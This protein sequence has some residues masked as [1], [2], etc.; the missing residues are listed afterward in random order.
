MTNLTRIKISYY[1]S[2]A[3][4]T[5]AFRSTL[6]LT[7]CKDE[8]RKGEIYLD[9]MDLPRYE[10]LKLKY[11]QKLMNRRL[12]NKPYD[13]GVLVSDVQTYVATLDSTVPSLLKGPPTTYP[14]SRSSGSTVAH[15]SVSHQTPMT[16]TGLTHMDLDSLQTI[17][18]PLEPAAPPS[19]GSTLSSAEIIST[20]QHAMGSSSR[21]SRDSGRNS[22]RG[23]KKN[24]NCRYCDKPGHFW[25]ECFTYEN[26]RKSNRLRAGWEEREHRSR[27]RGPRDGKAGRHK[28]AMRDRSTGG[29]YLR[30]RSP[31]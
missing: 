5:K 13:F 27:S 1:D 3:A 15:S 28:G 7:D 26:D 22:E 23:S 17:R 12:A 29:S 14:Q 2:F 31:V 9:A 19:T 10:G 25:R 21:Y 6:L 16:P 11:K 4:F 8:V 24:G 20:I 30:I 18:P